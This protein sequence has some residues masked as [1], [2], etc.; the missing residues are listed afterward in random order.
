MHQSVVRLSAQKSK[1]HF[2]V[3]VS[4]RHVVVETDK[5]DR[6]GRVVGKVIVGG[7]DI[8]LE[9]IK[10]GLAWH[11]KEYQNEQTAS[12]RQL[13]SEAEDEARKAKRGL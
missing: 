7:K 8:S 1:K 13:Y 9:Q 2:S 10:A 12:D 6:Y 4:G 11:Y 3:M 5:H